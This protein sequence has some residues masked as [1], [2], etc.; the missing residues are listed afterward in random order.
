MYSC[1]GSPYRRKTWIRKNGNKVVWRCLSRIEHGTAYCKHSVAVE[2]NQLKETICKGL[3]KAIHN[4]EKI[5]NLIEANLAYI[6]SGNSN[7]LNVYGLEQK[8]KELKQE[9]DMA[10]ER[11]TKTEGDKRK[12]EEGIKHIND[13]IAI[14]REQLEL[15]KSKVSYNENVDLEMSKIKQ[16][17]ASTE[18]EFFECDDTTIHRL[19]ENIRVMEDNTAIITLKGGYQIEEPIL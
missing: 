12:F 15:E 1:C 7:S 19:I 18:T 4:K 8:L 11:M 14:L 3:N 6:A 10:V 17:L 9:M 16:I 2:E 13:Q 5:N